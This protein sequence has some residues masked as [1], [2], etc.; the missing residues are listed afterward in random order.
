[1]SEE[2]TRNI[3]PRSFEERV[4]A[5]LSAIRT[6][7]SAIRNDVVVLGER[8]SSLERKVDS[9][10]EK[11]DRRLQETRPMWESVQAQIRKLDTK[12][13]IVIRELYEIRYDHVILGKRVEELEKT[14][15]Q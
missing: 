2:S 8:M 1:M 10:E 7:Q 5:E 9:L 14:G 12:F 15:T 6:E 4:L 11:V 13:D 3:P